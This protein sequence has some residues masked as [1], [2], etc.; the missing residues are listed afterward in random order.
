MSLKS[1]QTYYDAFAATYDAR[2]AQGYHAML[3]D[4]E[5]GLVLRYARGGDVL[6]AGCGTGLVLNRMAPYVRRAVGVDLSGGML[7]RARARGLTVAQ[8]SVLALPV[9]SASFDVVCCF[10]VLAHVEDIRSAMAELGRVVRPGGH[11]VAEF[12]NPRSVRG[13]LWR[14]KR[15]GRIAHG[16]DEKD[17]YV[18]FDTPA[19]AAG[20]LPDGFTSVDARGARVVTL[21]PQVFNL[22]VVGP[23]VAALETELADPLAALGSFYSLVARRHG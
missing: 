12:Y 15:P 22:P 2:R 19:Q 20:Y 3:D 23:L 14:L 16:L 4:L 1:N 5:A 10:K 21:A 17:V 11:L 9:A 6:E 8:G 18:R 7:A 13:L